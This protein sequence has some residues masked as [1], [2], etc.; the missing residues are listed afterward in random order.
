MHPWMDPR[1]ETRLWAAQNADIYR[2]YHRIFDCRAHGWAN[3]QSVHIN[4][5]F[6]DDREFA[7]LHAAVRLALP[8]LPAIAAASPFAE[9]RFTG[10]LDYRLEAYRCNAA[11]VPAMNG[12]MIPE[13]AV[14]GAQYQQEVLRPLYAAL[15]PL[16]PGGLLQYEWANARG[17]IP[18]FDRSALE[19]RVVDVQECPGADVAL[20]AAIVDLVRLFYD[21]R[22]APEA[23]TGELLAI[24]LA[25]MR[26][27][28]RA[29]IDSP[30]YGRRGEAREV[31]AAL[32]QRM[33]T[34]PHRTLWQ[35]HL[36]FVLSQGPLA[37]RMLQAVGPEP[38][39]DEL[40]LLYGRLRECLA[41]GRVFDPSSSS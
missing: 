28:E 38:A 4:L 18:R 26:D 19:I 30:L 36:D 37:R 5:P 22:R 1:T 32:A 3:V 17:A 9:G 13:P 2:A 8:L 24:L 20:A 31:W 14:S 33:G 15:S 34:A 21:E 27:A 25:C 29:R 40:A 6:A 23:D 11:A 16:D 12:R 10:W 39:R 35:P 7:R 41:R